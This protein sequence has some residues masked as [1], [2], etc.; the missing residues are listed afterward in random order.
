MELEIPKKFSSFVLAEYY[1]G[2]SCI[3]GFCSQE[4]RKLIGS[5][6]EYFA[7]GTFKSCPRPFYQL[8]IIYEEVGSSIDATNV[9]PMIFALLPDKKCTTFNFISI[10]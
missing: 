10:N 1:N 2:E 3:L 8:Y 5:I 4:S 6:K 7:D 9:I